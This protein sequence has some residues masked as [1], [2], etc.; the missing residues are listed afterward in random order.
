[1]SINI[2]LGENPDSGNRQPDR[3]NTALSVLL[4]IVL[5]V[6][7]VVVVLVAR[8]RSQNAAL[9]APGPTV[10]IGKATVIIGN[11]VTP[12]PATATPVKAAQPAM[13]PVVTPPTPAAVASAT[14]PPA[15]AA[16]AAPTAAPTKPGQTATLPAA[17]ASPTAAPTKPGETATAI[18]PTA[19]TA[20]ASPQPT[21]AST[22]R[23]WFFAEGA[24]VAP[25]RTWYDIFNPG[26]QPARVT[27]SLYPETGKAVQKTVTV[28]AGTQT[29]FLTND[30][31]PNTVF[32]A[33]I[34]SDQPVYVERLTV[35]DRDGTTASGM[36]PAK[37]WY[38]PEGQ[39]GDDFTTWLLVFNPNAT[40]ADLTVTY[41]PVGAKAVVKTYSAPPTARLTIAA[42][43]DVVSAVMGIVLESSQPVVAEHGI[44]FDNQKAAYGGPGLTATSK[45]WYVGS[46]NTQ[47]GFTAR[48]AVFNPNKAPAIIKVTLIGSK[49][50]PVSDL[51]SVDPL[52]K[53]DIV[54][55]DRAD[56]QLV[57]VILDSDQP[58]VA[59]SVTYYM[60]GGESGPVAAYSA[61]AVPAAAKEWYVPDVATGNE[62]DSYVALFNPGDA[63]ASVTVSYVLQG[64]EVVTKTY[65]VA[66]RSRTTLRAS[67]EVKG[68]VVDAAIVRSTQ[69]IAVERVTMFRNSVGATASAG[70]VAQ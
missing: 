65:N 23:T 22:V 44:Y 38:F 49:Q 35:G 10:A 20:A 30:V 39:T 46:G 64:A 69:P 33:G 53:D 29:H 18:L 48:V 67:D 43:K 32:S 8:Q 21:V 16:T 24:T 3:L 55:N 68:K 50:N 15:T 57:G 40:P 36:A 51:Y 42:Q 61:P 66:A 63:A 19:T 28:A 58:I 56:E 27:I 25:F 34:S 41:Y 17:T 37:V 26:S 5:F 62:Y 13:S 9:V 14:Q 60:S 31:L 70:I 2:D 54:L 52:S 12:V 45:T 47:I 4:A 59:G 1:M 11:T 7:I 6:A